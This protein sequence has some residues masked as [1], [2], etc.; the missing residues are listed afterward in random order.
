MIQKHNVILCI[1]LC[2]TFSG[3]P[4]GEGEGEG[5]G[6]TVRNREAGHEIWT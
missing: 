5:A 4:A 1:N 3:G 6:F 2:Y